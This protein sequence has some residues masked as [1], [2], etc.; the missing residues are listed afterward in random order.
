MPRSLKPPIWLSKNATSTLNQISTTFFFVILFP[1]SWLPVLP[2]ANQ[3]LIY[4]HFLGGVVGL[5][6]P[7]PPAAILL[8]P[9][10]PAAP[11]P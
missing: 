11:I 3:T 2:V 4:A 5:S 10:P 1:A 7:G 9:G 8:N 6:L